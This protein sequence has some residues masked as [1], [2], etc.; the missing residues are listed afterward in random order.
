MSLNTGIEWTDHT[1]NPWHGCHKVS[2]GCKNCYM[3]SDKKRYGQDPNLV[4]RSKTKFSGPLKWPKVPARCFTCSWSDWFIEEADGWREEAYDVIRATPHITYQ[5]LTKRFERMVGRVPD[6]V[7]PNIWFGVSVEDN[8]FRHRID[9]LMD[10]P[11]AK[12]FI[13]YEPALGPLDLGDYLGHHIGCYADEGSICVCG[14]RGKLDQVI[15]GGE[16]GPQARPFDIEW[17]RTTVRDCRAAGVPVFV[18]QLGAKAHDRLSDDS[19]WITKTL[20]QW[21]EMTRFHTKHPGQLLHQIELIDRKGGDM[22]EWPA[23]LRVREF[24]A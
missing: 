17:A 24:P 6:P 10:I 11:A 16:S 1:W 9:E 2:A 23:D 14:T 3:F 12:R 19:G 22:S 15:V 18:K 8:R 20:A 5:I 13:S 7:L 4:T 21:P